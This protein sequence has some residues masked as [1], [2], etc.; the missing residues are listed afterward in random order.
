MIKQYECILNLETIPKEI[1][2]HI[3]S[4]CP[5]IWKLSMS[6]TNKY[7]KNNIF[8]NFFQYTQNMDCCIFNDKILQFVKKYKE[9][10]C[11]GGEFISNRLYDIGYKNVKMDIFISTDLFPQYIDEIYQIFILNHDAIIINNEVINNYKKCYYP[12]L[13][14]DRVYEISEYHNIILL[15]YNEQTISQ[16]IRN[17]LMMEIDKN[18]Y[19]DRLFLS[20]TCKLFK[21]ETNV[22]TTKNIWLKKIN[23]K[24]NDI[25]SEKINLYKNNGFKIIFETAFYKGNN[26]HNIEPKLVDIENSIWMLTTNKYNH[27]YNKNCLV[28]K[29][30]ICQYVEKGVNF[31]LVECMF[32]KENQYVSTF[33]E[34]LLKKDSYFLFTNKK[35]PT[36]LQEDDKEEKEKEKEIIVKHCR[37]RHFD[38]HKEQI[39]KKKLKINK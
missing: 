21:K 29:S 28:K 8:L 19:T 16:Y 23:T 22:Y 5:Y 25:I 26:Y 14:I 6:L 39:V 36:L 18:Y 30:Q 35:L 37:K 4:F 3:V 11:I 12:N 27:I 2:N 10:V 15:K 7:M 13:A 33:S 24:T 34:N 38:D 20:D 9:S 17:N 1:L 32:K 31:H